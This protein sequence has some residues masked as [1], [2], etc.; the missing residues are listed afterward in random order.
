MRT[1]ETAL[2]V[3]TD[4]QLEGMRNY[5]KAF[6]TNIACTV[7]TV[8]LAMRDASPHFSAKITYRSFFFM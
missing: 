7:K 5:R 6:C 8:M 4:I 2:F 3:A 1:T